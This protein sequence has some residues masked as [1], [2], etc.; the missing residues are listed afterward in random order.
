ME[1]SKRD[2]NF[3]VTT[4]YKAS[5]KPFSYGSSVKLDDYNY[6][7]W[8]RTF[9]M[10]VS[11]HQGKYILLEPE[12]DK[13]IDK[14]AT[15]VEDND[16][17]MLGIMNSVQPYIVD[18]LVYYSMAKEM[19]DNLKDM[20]LQDKNVNCVLQAEYEIFKIQQGDQTLA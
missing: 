10:S 12:P 8:S 20:Y 2:H 14:Y 9:M 13:K 16:I 6:E 17:V 11:G 18:G 15:W 3:D 5:A 1:D 4:E 7:R 19:W